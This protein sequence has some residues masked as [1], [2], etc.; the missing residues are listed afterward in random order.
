MCHYRAH[1][2]ASV[3]ILSQINPL[4]FPRSYFCRIHLILPSS[5]RFFK[6][7]LSFRLTLLNPICIPPRLL[8]CNTSR[9]SYCPAFPQ[10]S[11]ILWA[12]QITELHFM[13]S[14]PAFSYSPRLVSSFSQPPHNNSHGGAA[15]ELNKTLCVSSSATAECRRRNG[16]CGSEMLRRL[17]VWFG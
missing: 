16:L 8:A 2:S 1:R 12:V 10:P 13:Q 17:F 4:H 3:R 6:W 14:F 5:F 9:L 11:A 15:P 7:S